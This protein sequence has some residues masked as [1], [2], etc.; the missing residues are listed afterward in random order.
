MSNK[1]FIIEIENTKATAKQLHDDLNFLGYTIVRIAEQPLGDREYPLDTPLNFHHNLGL[2][3]YIIYRLQR[4]GITT[5]EHLLSLTDEEILLLRGI[6]KK[7]LAV[8]KAALA[9]QEYPG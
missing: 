5:I 1:T 3:N 8:I 6:G 7:S 2:P 9:K 4:A